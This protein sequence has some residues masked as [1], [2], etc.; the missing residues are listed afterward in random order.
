VLAFPSEVLRVRSQLKNLKYVLLAAAIGKQSGDRKQPEVFHITSFERHDIE[1][2][3][4]FIALS[5]SA[6]LLNRYLATIED[7]LVKRLRSLSVKELEALGQKWLD[8]TL[9]RNLLAWL[10]QQ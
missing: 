10:A 6:R 2:G 3:N 1:K 4:H 9:V 5:S 8:F 7:K